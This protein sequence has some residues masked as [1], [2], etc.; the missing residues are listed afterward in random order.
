MNTR[1]PTSD[2][3]YITFSNSHPNSRE[4]L[5]FEEKLLFSLCEISTKINSEFKLSLKKE[6]ESFSQKKSTEKYFQTAAN[7]NCVE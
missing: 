1:F 3:F 2:L 4:I 6:N 5:L 7:S